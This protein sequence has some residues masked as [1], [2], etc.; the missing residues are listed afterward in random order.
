MI[1]IT[2]SKL[3][4]FSLPATAAAPPVHVNSAGNYDLLAARAETHGDAIQ[5]EGDAGKENLGFW[6][7]PDDWAS[8]TVDFASSGTYEVSALASAGTGPTAFNME[9]SGQKLTVSV[10]ATGSWA[11]YIHLAVGRIT[12]PKMGKY[13]ISV[14][15][16]DHAS[17]KPMNLRGLV[18]RK[19]S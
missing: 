10:P 5:V 19:T 7:N 2:G 1:K 6:D 18:F 17:W 4:E 9:V 13:V 8:W 14:K 3:R 16:A 15:A 12:L 11:A